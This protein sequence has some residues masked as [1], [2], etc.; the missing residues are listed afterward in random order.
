LDVLVDIRE[1]AVGIVDGYPE[2]LCAGR[3]GKAARD[4]PGEIDRDRWKGSRARHLLTLL[5]RRHFP[6]GV[7]LYQVGSETCA[8]LH[9][10][11]TIQGVCVCEA[12]HPHTPCIVRSEE[13][14]CELQSR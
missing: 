2:I 8:D 14:T 9:A 13:H 12:E 11:P 6:L 3:D 1:P 7:G 10:L 5:A 4:A